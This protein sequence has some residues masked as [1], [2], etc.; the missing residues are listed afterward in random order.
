MAEKTI[1]II[2][3]CCHILEAHKKGRTGFG[4]CACGSL[5]IEPNGVEHEMGKYLGEMTVPESE[6]RGL[7]Y[8]V[9]EA[10]GITTGDLEIR[11]DSELVVRWMTGKNRI[12]A[13]HIRPLLDEAK[14]LERR[15]RSV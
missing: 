12:H 7:L 13:K 3:A 4:K 1:I 14:K 6:F 11:M 8:A 9:E 5:A 2:D 15:Y 10:I